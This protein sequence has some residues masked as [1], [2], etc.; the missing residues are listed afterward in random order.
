[1]VRIKG[2]L[3]VNTPTALG[4]F[5]NRF[6]SMNGIGNFYNVV[7]TKII[8]PS[9]SKYNNA[10]EDD[11]LNNAT[12]T[13]TTTTISDSTDEMLEKL[14]NYF[15]NTENEPLHVCEKTINKKLGR[16]VYTTVTNETFEAYHSIVFPKIVCGEVVYSDKVRWYEAM[17]STVVEPRRLD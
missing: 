5:R 11:V 10:V 4:R 15:K 12:T 9:N 13:T 7:L 8:K 6:N 3:T 17:R 14:G 1:M 2:E 16:L